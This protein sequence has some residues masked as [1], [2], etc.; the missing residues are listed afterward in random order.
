MIGAICSAGHDLGDPGVGNPV[1]T[2]LSNPS[3]WQVSFGYRWQDSFRHFRGGHEEAHRVEE[4]TEVQNKLHL[5]DLALSYQVSPRW[6]LNVGVPFS[7]V[8]RISHRN[9]TLTHSGGIGDMSVGAKFWIFRPPTESG[10]NIQVGLSMKLPTGNPSVTNQVGPNTV[11]V[12]QSIQLGDSGT[13]F[14]LDYTAFKSMGRFTLFSTG[15]YLFNPKNT[16]TPSG[17]NEVA[18]RPPGYPGFSRAGTIYSVAD[19][20]LFQVGA[21]YAVPKLN[22]LALT[23]TGRIEG[24][25]ARDI[26]GG[27]DGFR[28]PGYAVSVGPGVMY[29]RGRD[30]WSLS[31]PIAVYRNRT[32]SVS[33]VERGSHGD[34][35]F[36]D[37]L[38]LVGYSRNF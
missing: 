36:A 25:P 34:A 7:T 27:E 11:V 16:H 1:T 15:V 37:Y 10:Q 29:S 18:P 4:G 5:F 2:T 20:Y 30:T 28:R 33:D 22:G 9:D 12:D 14:S 38:I 21:G 3:R 8:D 23:A 19:Q 24:V 31:V 26:I 32:R 13:G 35:A 17:W 6:S